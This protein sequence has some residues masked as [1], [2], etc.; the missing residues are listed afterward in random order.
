MAVS[1]RPDYDIPPT[2]LP[3]CF[4][5]RQYGKRKFNNEGEVYFFHIYN[6]PGVVRMCG[7]QP[8]EIFELEFRERREGDPETPYWG[9]EDFKENTTSRPSGYSMIWHAYHLFHMCFTYGDKAEVE[10]GNGRPV[11]LL[12]I[13]AKPYEEQK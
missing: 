4:I 7:A 1:T 11:N 8:S 10:R 6:H 12:L 2:Q 5:L 3:E 13:S 9:W